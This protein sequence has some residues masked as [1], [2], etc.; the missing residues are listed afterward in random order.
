MRRPVTAMLPFEYVGK[1]VERKAQE[2]E[3]P[4][5]LENEGPIRYGTGRK[6]KTRAGDPIMLAKARRYGLRQIIRTSGASQHSV[7]RFLRGERV[8]PSTR[9][10]IEKAVGRL[11]REG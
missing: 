9:M 10:A 1:E 6:A 5:V 11:G 3:D 2:G 4:A 8:H 7:E